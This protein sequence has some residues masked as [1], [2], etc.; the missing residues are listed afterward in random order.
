MQILKVGYGNFVNK[1]KV[2]AIASAD[3]APIKRIITQ[4]KA[5]GLLIDTTKGRKT[6]AV[7]IAES[8]HIILSY[9]KPEDLQKE[10]SDKSEAKN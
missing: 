7:I 5:K 3:S 9:L 4:A 6:D 1:D 2:V 10:F 8:G